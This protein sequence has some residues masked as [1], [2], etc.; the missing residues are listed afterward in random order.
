MKIK[1]TKPDLKN[2]KK[3]KK[4]LKMKLRDERRDNN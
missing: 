4:Y 2:T 1:L 3:I